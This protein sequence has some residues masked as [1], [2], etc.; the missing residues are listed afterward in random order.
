MST[1]VATA[2]QDVP[3]AVV[4]AAGPV[5]SHWEHRVR[6]T[7]DPYMVWCEM[8]THAF[9]I[10]LRLLNSRFA[11][12]EYGSN[13]K[14]CTRKDNCRCSAG[15]YDAWDHESIK[16]RCHQADMDA[17]GKKYYDLLYLIS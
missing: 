10:K 13:C 14:Q 3:Q 4:P 12:S 16:L 17:F 5:L 1:F 15:L 9:V 6:E 8:N 2:A 7:N 11:L